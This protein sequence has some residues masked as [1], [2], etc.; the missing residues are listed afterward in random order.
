[1]GLIALSFFNEFAAAFLN[2]RLNT[3]LILDSKIVQIDG[4]N[5]YLLVS[6]LTKT[7][8]CNNEREEFK[9]IGNRPRDGVFGACFAIDF[10]SLE[11]QQKKIAV[12]DKFEYEKLLMNNV[13]IYC[14]RPGMRLWQ[15]DLNGN[16]KRTHQYKN[17]NFT[18]EKVY[19]LKD[20]S[21][22]DSSPLLMDKTNQFQLINSINNI[23]VLTWNSSGFY[24]I[25]PSLSKVLF[26]SQEFNMFIT[27]VK[28][29]SNSIFLFLKDGR[30]LEL[31]LFKLEH[32][33]I[34]LCQCED[35]MK[36]A[37]VLTDNLEYFL[38]L[39][40]NIQPKDSESNQFR[41]FLKIR[42]SLITNDSI[43]MLKTLSNIFDVLSSKKI[44]NV[45]ILN[46]N[47]SY[48]SQQREKEDKEV[49]KLPQLKKEPE[50]DD[51]NKKSIKRAIRQLYILHQTSLISKINFRERLGKIFDDFQNSSIIKILED[52]ENL[53]VENS[54]YDRAESKKV[55]SK[56]FL[57]YLQPEIIFE[58]D[59][60]TTLNYIANALIEIQSNQHIGISRCHRCDFPL[61]SGSSGAQGYEEIGIILQQF[62]WSRGEYDKCFQ[63]CHSLPY[64]LKITGKFITDE[65]KFDKMIPYAINLG[66]LEILHKALELF[67]DILFF[68]QLL[69]DYVLA[70]SGKFKCLK[71][72]EMN[73]ISEVHRI[74]TW[75]CLFQAIEFYLYGDELIELIMRFSE[76]IPNGAL[77]RHFYMKLLLHATD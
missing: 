13:M 9:Q 50:N 69:D 10:E 71:C 60:E 40:H 65:K 55:V 5:D 56:M 41:V 70:C 63:L 32:Y 25:D 6:S 27:S 73:E 29:V 3:I 35:Y 61:N 21:E 39:L 31:T 75:D 38:H 7:I 12:I 58:I 64:L 23:F 54:D 51:E 26:W 67:S 22:A 4:F 68:K 46:K 49:E 52:L 36:A 15:A 18:N 19:L 2:I 16:I 43:D 47:T 42:D 24:I 77:S 14:S 20:N 33:A 28:V 66:D 30:L 45:V 74:L 62:Y 37:R 34:Q 17:A 53:F 72:D 11:S 48:E 8:L 76:H 59:D 44:Q 1:M 57:D